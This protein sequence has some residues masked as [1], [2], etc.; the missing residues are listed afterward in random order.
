MSRVFSPMG[1][2]PFKHWIASPSD[3]RE[4]RSA[5]SMLQE[6]MRVPNDPSQAVKSSSYAAQDNDDFIILVRLTDAPH[7]LQVLL[8]CLQCHTLSMYVSVRTG[9]V[10]IPSVSVDE[11]IPSSLSSSKF[12]ELLDTEFCNFDQERSCEKFKTGQVWALYYKLDK[13]PKTYVQIECVEL[14]LV[15]KLSAKWLKSCDPPRRI[16]PWVDKEM[17][18]SCGIFKVTSSEVVFFYD[19]ISFSHQ[20]D[21]RSLAASDRPLD[22]SKATSVPNGD[23]NVVAPTKKLSLDG[24]ISIPGNVGEDIPSPPS[25]LK[26]IKM[27]V[28]RF[29][30]F[31]V[32]R[33]C[34]MFKTG[35]IWALYCKLD[36]L[37]KTYAQ[38]ESF[39][40]FPG[41][42]L[43]VKLLKS[44][45]PPR[46]IIPWI[47]KEI[48]VSCGTFKVT[49][50]ELVVFKDSISFSH[51][52]S[53]VPA[54][55]N[56]YTIHPKAGEVWALYR[57][58]CGQLRG[59]WEL[60]PRSLA[61]YRYSTN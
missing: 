40:S 10:A 20:L 18:V 52:L 27:P 32:V 21:I 7:K 13:F 24:V 57:A 42:K 45:D 3:E 48:P 56:V 5:N 22:K 33:S 4:A 2:C 61:V 58:R 35:Q 19:S 17:P 1:E 44:C 15:F 59:C 49:S 11:A 14:F 28:T 53:K 54:V 29:C 6:L 12:F 38:I 55:N 8:T 23:E 34:E 41:F 47:G 26:T 46:S 51:Q 31:D 39:K 9:I 60:D 30:N 36:K 50:S 25:S 43:V 37:P 16:I